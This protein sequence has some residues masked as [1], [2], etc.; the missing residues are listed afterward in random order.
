MPEG[1]F[2]VTNKIEILFLVNK[3]VLPFDYSL[4]NEETNLKYLVHCL[5]WTD[6]LPCQG[7]D[8]NLRAL[9][10]LML[11]ENYIFLAQRKTHFCQL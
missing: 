5:V 8:L 1:P 6:D 4:H 3:A 2:L 11:Q 9:L 10:P 7:A